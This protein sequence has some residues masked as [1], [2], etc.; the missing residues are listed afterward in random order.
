MVSNGSAPARNT[1]KIVIVGAGFAGLGMA[2]Q[3]T[4]AGVRDF[5]ILERADAVGGTWRDNTYPGCAV[6]VKSHL[7][8]YSFA[9]NPNWSQTYAPHDELLAYTHSIVE[10]FGLM[11]YV[12][13]NHE[14]EGAVWDEADAEWRI[15]TSQGEYAAQF[16]ISATGPLSRPVLPDIP[17]LES[18]KGTMFH[19]GQWDHGHDLRGERVGV[20]GNGS[21]SCQLVPQIQPV[22]DSLDVYQRTPS[23]IIPRMNRHTYAWERALYRAFP[24][25]QRA[26]RFRQYWT[27]EAIAWTWL[28]KGRGRWLEGVAK[29]RLRKTVSDPV[30]RAKLTPDYDIGCKRIVISDAFWPAIDK[31]N[32]DL[33]TDPI[34]EVTE[35]GIRTRN[36]DGGTT[37]RKLDTIILA[38]G[39]KVMPIVDPLIGRGGTTLQ[40]EW[41]ETRRA[42]LGTAVNGY[43]NYFTLLGPYTFNGHTS[44]LVWAE[45]QMDYIMQ[46]LDAMERTG[47]RSL[48]VRQESQDGYTEEVRRR[49]QGTVWTSGGC[50]SW[51]LDPDGGTSVVFPG[52]TKQFVEGLKKFDPADY[53]LS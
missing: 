22:V 37:V 7:Y 16:L 24:A 20:I 31:P 44:I 43:P 52:Y 11:R 46:A 51:Y 19:S 26:V 50:N 47:K 33:V 29:W 10:K 49:L 2:V 35:D 21:S 41:K 36:A 5:V 34:V 8:S 28:K 1:V 30:K 32:V 4:K 14:V 48:E 13:L 18:F 17:G 40:D 3:L 53:V 6:D 27:Q 42:F 45:A 9:P 23:W 25:V 12:R 39:Y 15:A 38:S